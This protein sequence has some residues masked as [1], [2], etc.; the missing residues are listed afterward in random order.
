M[1]RSVQRLYFIFGLLVLTNCTAWWPS[2]NALGPVAV[3]LEPSEQFI[4]TLNNINQTLRVTPT[5]IFTYIKAT[6][7]IILGTWIGY[8]GILKM[9]SAIQKAKEKQIQ[10]NKQ[11]TEVFGDFLQGDL[12]ALAGLGLIA[13]SDAIIEWVAKQYRTSAN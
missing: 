4:A 13:K 12:L 5:T 2:L 1:N 10:D 7:L 3:K 6:P 11:K 8:S 9:Y